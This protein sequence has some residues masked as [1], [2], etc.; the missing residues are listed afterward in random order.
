[1]GWVFKLWNLNLE[2]LNSYPKDLAMA[3]LNAEDHRFLESVA[4]VSYANP[5]LAER[6]D[7]ERQA[8]GSEF[9]ES[10]ANWNLLGDDPESQ[11]INTR[12]IA[13]RAY[14]IIAGVRQLFK[15]GTAGNRTELQLYEDTVLFLLYYYYAQRFKDIIVKPQKDQ[16]YEYFNEF[17]HYW[18][19]FFNLPVDKLPSQKEASHIFAC[20]FQ[21]RRAFYCYRRR[22]NAINVAI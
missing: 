9:D 5:F 10:Q 11:Q 12:K 1:M 16:T 14:S 2:T 22:E 18:R 15:K 6:I 20:F 13:E 3:I 4:E 7:Y 19:H 21:V 17:T 8:L